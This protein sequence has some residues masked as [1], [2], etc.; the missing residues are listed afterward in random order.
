MPNA[1]AKTF[2]VSNLP[3]FLAE[4]DFH[5]FDSRWL[6]FRVQRYKNIYKCANFSKIICINR[7]KVVPL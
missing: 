7:K 2:A 3:T 6:I 5:I 1:C 4:L